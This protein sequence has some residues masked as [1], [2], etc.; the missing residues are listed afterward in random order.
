MA[1]RKGLSSDEIA[2]LLREISDNELDGSELSCSNLDSDED[3]GVK[4]PTLPS[5]PTLPKPYT[6]LLKNGRL[7]FLLKKCK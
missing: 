6:P 1:C 7:L 5:P 4:P 2:N 3:A